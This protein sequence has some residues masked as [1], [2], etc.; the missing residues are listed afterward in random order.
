MVTR[1]PWKSAGS[2]TGTSSTISRSAQPRA[3]HVVPSAEDAAPT[4]L[5]TTCTVPSG[6]IPMRIRTSPSPSAKGCSGGEVLDGP[7]VLGPGQEVAAIDQGKGRYAT[8]DWHGDLHVV[9][10]EGEVVDLTGPASFAVDVTFAGGDRLVSR[11]IDGSTYLWDV[12]TSRLVGRLWQ[13]SPSA[14]FGMEV[15]RAANDL[16]HVTP[17]G[18]AR[19]PLAPDAWF[20]TFCPRVDRRLTDT[21]R[22]AIAPDLAPGPGCPGDLGEV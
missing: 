6:A 15:D 13:S 17:E 12:A 4:G 22:T 16:L 11:H 18:I 21:E 19:I 20:D 1:R 3:L 2:P 9:D 10:P 8:A 7:R 14:F 5:L